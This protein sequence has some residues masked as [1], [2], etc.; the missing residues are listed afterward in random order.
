M[1]LWAPRLASPG[2]SRRPAESEAAMHTADLFED[3]LPA[4]QA[5]KPVNAAPAAE[6]AGFEIGWD[7]AHHRLTPPPQYLADGHAVRQGWLAGTAVFGTRTLKPTVHVRK[8]LQ[9]RL[10]K[11]G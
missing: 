8:W 9:L 11:A 7:F 3:T 6:A 10:R 2:S 1:S 5:L 4:V